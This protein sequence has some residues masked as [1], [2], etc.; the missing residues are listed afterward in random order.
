MGAPT[1]PPTPEESA[2][3]FVEE[4][5]EE[6]RR[7]MGLDSDEE[8]EQAI[9]AHFLFAPPRRELVSGEEVGTPLDSLLRSLTAW[10]RAVSDGDVQISTSDPASTDG[11]VL[12]LPRAA[13][14]PVQPAEDA[15]L[16][17]VMALVQVGFLKFGLLDNRRFVAELHRDWVLR[18]CYTLLCVHHI[19]A[20]W[21]A[22]WPGI[23]ADFAAVRF[24]DKA[25]AMRVNTMEV[26]RKGMP[27]AFLPLYDGLTDFMEEAGAEGEA[28]RK[29]VAAVRAI[30]DPKTAGPILMG[31]AQSLRMTF[32]G[33]RLGPPPLPWFVGII[34]PEWLL[35]DL[36][37]EMEAAHEWKKG[38]KPLRQLLAAKLKKGEGSSL[39]DRIKRSLRGERDGPPPPADAPTSQL[40]VR[41]KDDG[42]RSYDEWD[43]ARGIYKIAA[44]RVVPIDAPG[45][46][47][48]NYEKIVHANQPQIKEIRRKFE[49]LRIEERWLHGQTDGSEIDLNRA[50]AALA[51]IQAG[52]SP[53]TDWYI[54]F[55]RQRQDVAILTMVDL[56]GSTQ[57]NI[58]AL[59]QQAIV[60]FA[61][62]LRVLNFP[63]AFHGF[64]N[65]GP[66]QCH[67]QRM[68]DWDDPYDEATCKRLAN[69]RPGG[70]TRL[71]AFIRHATWQLSQR[72]E[73]RRILMLL[74]DGRPHDRGEY[75]ESYGMHDSAMA[76]M[77]SRRQGV[78][79]FCISMDNQ[80][81]AEGYLRNIFGPGRYLLLDNLDDLP[82][83]LPEVFRSLIK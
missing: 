13:P 3:L 30:A 4:Y 39:P 62:G 34:R 47:L 80:E 53:R 83:R 35:H 25:G 67:V 33:M 42:S 70:A 16:F 10:L 31:Q 26:P 12:F 78:Y 36:R 51:D 76:I 72:P 6:A 38:Q 45:G 27:G 8:A 59:E 9:L 74:S 68:K 19:A 57:G 29:A 81:G 82:A 66:N 17:R 69:L 23:K 22:E 32:K 11:E 54:R 77:E 56:S 2:R 64:S 60:M 71:G 21:S 61:E 58:I 63:H 15:L 79:T 50:I 20:R 75:A 43:Q 49:A 14:A 7:I 40:E 18:S 52:F 37:E 1:W 5:G 41:P 55:Q 44:T 28:A 73:G 46:P 24:L 65:R 48:E